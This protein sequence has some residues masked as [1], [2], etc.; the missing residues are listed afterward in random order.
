MGPAINGLKVK[1]KGQ[2]YRNWPKAKRRG[3]VAYHLPLAVLGK[4]P[5]K[6]RITNSI[7]EVE[8]RLRSNHTRGHKMRSA[9]G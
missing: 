6:Y 7:L 5:Q 1:G 9:E 4:D 3:S 8:D 2:A